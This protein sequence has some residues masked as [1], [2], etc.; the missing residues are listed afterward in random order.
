[1]ISDL[2]HAAVSKRQRT[3]SEPNN[4]YKL[5]HHSSIG[6]DFEDHVDLTNVSG[7]V[8]GLVNLVGIVFVGWNLT[9]WS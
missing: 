5:H 6:F 7:P 8:F 4:Y 3:Y 1:M 9:S 2:L